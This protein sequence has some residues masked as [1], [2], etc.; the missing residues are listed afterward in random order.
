MIEKKKN[1]LPPPKKKYLS[2]QFET[3]INLSK[4]NDIT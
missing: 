3:N 2:V 4:N 1:R